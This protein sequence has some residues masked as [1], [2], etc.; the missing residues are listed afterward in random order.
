MVFFND[1]KTIII[2]ITTKRMLLIMVADSPIPDQ[3]CPLIFAMQNH[4]PVG[5]SKLY[6]QVISTLLQVLT[7]YQSL[8]SLFSLLSLPIFKSFS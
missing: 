2:I 5:K 3:D 6:T 7:L 8:A 4:Y 1:I